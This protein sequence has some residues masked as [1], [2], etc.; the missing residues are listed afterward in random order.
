MLGD[1]NH[2]NQDSYRCGGVPVAMKNDAFTKKELELIE[3]LF[4]KL[5]TAT[6]KTLSKISKEGSE[7]S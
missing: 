1:I 7:S 2:N 4:E 3:R 6:R 5:I